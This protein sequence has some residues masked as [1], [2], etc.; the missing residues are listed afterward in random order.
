ML[1]VPKEIF[2]P[3]GVFLTYEDQIFFSELLNKFNILYT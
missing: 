2:G 1:K 3:R